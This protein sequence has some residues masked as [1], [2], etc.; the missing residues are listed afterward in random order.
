MN[1]P[2]ALFLNAVQHLLSNSFYDCSVFN[3]QYCIYVVLRKPLNEILSESSP[4]SA[5]LIEF[6]RTIPHNG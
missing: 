5:Y 4:F 2:H 1:N 3:P 6:L